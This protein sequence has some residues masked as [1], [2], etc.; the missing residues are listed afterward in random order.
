MKFIPPAVSVK[1][2]RTLLVG[3][4]HSPTILFGVGVVAGVASTVMACRATLKLED[5][6]T[7][8]LDKL[9]QA[10]TLHEDPTA[11]NYSTAD[12]QK[13]RLYIYTR[14]AVSVC[15][16]YAPAVGLGAVSV[17]ALTGSHKILNGR[18]AALTAA[19]AAVEKGFADYR[20]RVVEKYGEDEDREFRHGGTDVT[21]KDEETG[22][23]RKGRAVNDEL[24]PSMYARVFDETNR[25]WQKSPEYNIFFLRCQQNTANDQLKARGHIFLNEVYDLL[26]ME[27]SPAGAV[28]GWVYEGNGDSYVDF[29]VFNGNS[30]TTIDFVNGREGAVWLDFNVDGTIYDKI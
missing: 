21:F 18:N 3:K 2:A 30:P 29:G 23:T 22:K 19:Y 10:N 20:G 5:A 8:H 24:S 9:A 16:L 4:K 27:R 11:T 15:K 25:H 7:E 26:G 12:F 13:D 14:S 17:A 28:V 1:A 6:L